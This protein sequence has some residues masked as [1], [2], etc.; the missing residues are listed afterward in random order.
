MKFLGV[1]IGTTT[2]SAV[3]TDPAVGV[4]AAMNVKNDTFL[5]GEY[6]ERMQDPQK[7]W[8][9]AENCVRVMLARFPDVQGIG[10]TGQ[11]HGILY[12]NNCGNA[13]SPLYTWQDGRGDLP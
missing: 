8:K 2:I 7:I 10:V 6:W 4:L 3:V 13:V 11:M 9:S 1:D 12:L 5:P